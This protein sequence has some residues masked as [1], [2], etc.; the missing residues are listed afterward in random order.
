MKPTALLVNTS[1]RAADRRGRAGDA[2]RPAGPEW[3]GR[4]SMRKSRCATQHPLAQHGQRDLHAA[5]RLRHARRVRDSVRRY[6]RPDH[7]LC[8]GEP[9]NVVNPD[10]LK[11]DTRRMAKAAK[12]LHR[13]DAFLPAKP[14]H[15][16]GSSSGAGFR[17]KMLLALPD[18]ILVRRHTPDVATVVPHLPAAADDRGARAADRNSRANSSSILVELGNISTI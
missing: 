5:S 16:P 8:G 17:R 3:P 18:V 7:G 11:S 14:L 6:L 4:R 13:V 9:I 1:P 10:V 2:L 15:T 12:F